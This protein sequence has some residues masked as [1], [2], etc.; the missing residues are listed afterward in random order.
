MERRVQCL[1]RIVREQ[2]QEME[3]LIGIVLTRNVSPIDIG[4]QNNAQ[5][6]GARALAAPTGVI[7]RFDTEIPNQNFYFHDEVTQ[8][9]ASGGKEVAIRQRKTPMVQDQSWDAKKK[10]P[11][12]V[13]KK[14]KAPEGVHAFTRAL[15]VQPAVNPRNKPKSANNLRVPMKQSR[16]VNAVSIAAVS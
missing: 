3:R 13:E 15:P 4:F 5:T 12:F 11:G 9:P 8:P 7:P 2:Q 14:D 1:E 16:A 6:A 10:V